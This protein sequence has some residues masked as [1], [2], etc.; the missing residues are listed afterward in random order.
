[1]FFA[2]LILRFI[3][4]QAIANANHNRQQSI[5]TETTYGAETTSIKKRRPPKSVLSL[6]S[7]RVPLTV[8]PFELALFYPLRFSLY[9]TTAQGLK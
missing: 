5:K 6:F 2:Q 7:T 3:K 1:M 8:T 9:S 4:R